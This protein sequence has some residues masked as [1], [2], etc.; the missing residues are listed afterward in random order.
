MANLLSDICR[1]QKIAKD[2][3][4][5]IEGDLKDSLE[6]ALD[7][8]IPRT[9]NSVKVSIRSN[10]KETYTYVFSNLLETVEFLESYNEERDMDTSSVP[11][12]LTGRSVEP[13]ATQL[14]IE[15]EESEESELTPEQLELFEL[16]SE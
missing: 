1:W 15:S 14:L 12:L 16:D 11:P 9:V 5:T 13:E 10:L 8:S 2:L 6:L 4:A 7:D 3:I